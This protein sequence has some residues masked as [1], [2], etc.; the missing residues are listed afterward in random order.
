VLDQ[1]AYACRGE[2][3]AVLVRLDLRGDAD[4]HLSLSR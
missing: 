1:L 4:V 2:R 3:D